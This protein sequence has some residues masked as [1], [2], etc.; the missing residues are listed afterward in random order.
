MTSS[1]QCLKKGFNLFIYVNAFFLGIVLMSLEMLGSRYLNPYF[2]SS[3]YIWAA[4]ISTVL[5]ALAIGYF[6]GG[7]LA[8]RSPFPLF[9]GIVV[10]CAAYYIALIPLFYN[11]L[12]AYIYKIL[13]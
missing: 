6:L 11:Q 7:A 2:G 8:D 1:R 10:L 5:L 4:L 3:I 9:L 12:C 13:P